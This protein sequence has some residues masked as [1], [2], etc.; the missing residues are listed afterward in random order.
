MDEKSLELMGSIVDEAREIMKKITN[1][2]EIIERLEEMKRKNDFDFFNFNVKF[3]VTYG[4]PV[5]FNDSAAQA[6][7]DYAIQ[8]L[9]DQIAKLEAEF[10]KL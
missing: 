2:I 1:S 10:T 8:Y 5:Y 3:S 4:L 9:Y 7:A 6:L